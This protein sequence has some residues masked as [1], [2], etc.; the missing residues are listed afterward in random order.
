MQS[1]LP[2]ALLLVIVAA[3]LPLMRRRRA[4]RRQLAG[5]ALRC[6]WTYTPDDPWDLA[7][8]IEGL[9]LGAWGHDRRFRDVFSVP[10]QTGSLWLTEFSRQM[11]SGRRRRT[12]RFAVALASMR[13]ARGGVAILPAGALFV[14]ADP[15]ARYRR[16]TSLD[17][18]DLTGRQVWAERPDSDRSVLVLLSGL[19]LQLPQNGGDR[20]PRPGGGRLLASAAS[21]QPARLL[22]PADCRPLAA[23]PARAACRGGRPAGRHEPCGLAWKPVIL[24]VSCGLSCGWTAKTSTLAISSYGTDTTNTP[25]CQASSPGTHWA[26]RQTLVEPVDGLAELGT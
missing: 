4:R 24:A 13:A 14:A 9:C 22:R 2:V 16:V 23:G 15:F 25:A 1:L 11:A 21:Q 10:T 3:I 7:G 5:L 17:D 8:E 20:G 6:G 19:M 18:I 12:E 26:S